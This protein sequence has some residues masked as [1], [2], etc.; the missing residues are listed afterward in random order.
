[1]LELTVTVGLIDLLVGITVC[2]GTLM[3]IGVLLYWM[4]KND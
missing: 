1:M 4:I 3:F 2:V